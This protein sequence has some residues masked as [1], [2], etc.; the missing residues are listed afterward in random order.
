MIKHK[1]AAIVCIFLFILI[2]VSIGYPGRFQ[3][4]SIPSTSEVSI[5]TQSK[6]SAWTWNLDKENNSFSAIDT[7]TG[8]TYSGD[9]AILP[10]GY[11]ELTITSTS[12]PH[13]AIPESVFGHE[14]SNTA[15][16]FSL[17]S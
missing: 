6:D 10:N 16:W 17:I 2:I 14:I 4:L 15:F 3:S 7:T 9:L 5:G 1:F 12:D 13:I 11:L 8:Y